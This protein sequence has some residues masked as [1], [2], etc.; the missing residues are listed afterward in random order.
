MAVSGVVRVG[1][2]G[3]GAIARAAHLPVLG[4]MSR[5][6]VVAL[7]D[8]DDAARSAAARLAPN[9]A[10][11]TNHRELLTRAD[12]D[13]VVIALPTALHAHVARDAVQRGK[14]IYLEKPF[15][16]TLEEARSIV[17][18]AAR[19]TAAVRALGLNYRFNPLVTRARARI[20]AG[21]IGRVIAVQSVFSTTG[22]G[23]TTWKRARADGGGALLDLGSHHIDLIPWMLDADVASVSAE[24]RSHESE[25][26]CA[27]VRLSLTNG[28]V[29]QSFFSFASVE[30][31]RIIVFGERGRVV[32]D[33]YGAHDV[34]VDAPLA[35]ARG[36]A[37]VARLTRAPIAIRYAL[38]KRR[39][40]MHEPSY[41]AALEHFV[42]AVGGSPYLG[43]SFVDGLRVAA[44]IDAAERSARSGMTE[45][46]AEVNGAAG[47]TSV[48]DSHVTFQEELM[49]P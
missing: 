45:S 4:R 31:D 49:A 43:A 22:R 3:C 12:V 30:D 48:G 8:P 36:L 13:A 42:D 33:R 10:T 6:R 34:H 20:T 16:A 23:M 14:H 38:R 37:K 32:L 28:A 26:D 41:A 11:F 35:S 5:V 46:L 47:S 27:T 39:S 25:E 40:P 17:A 18:S 2:I 15:A 1:V 19:S 29:V 7:A 9:A 24:L 44:V 21:E